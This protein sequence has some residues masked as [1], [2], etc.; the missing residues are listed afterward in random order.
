[1]S[2]DKHRIITLS[3]S[4]FGFYTVT[5]ESL[6]KDEDIRD[7]AAEIFKMLKSFDERADIRWDS[8]NPQK[9]TIILPTGHGFTENKLQRIISIYKNHDC[10]LEV[11]GNNPILEA[12]LQ[13]LLKKTEHDE[14][15]EGESFLQNGNETIR[16][17]S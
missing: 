2:G 5:V 14:R 13:K 11:G 6:L 16:P 10:K 3:N 17:K 4:A 12:Q 9:V 15:R 1:M 8:P 7:I